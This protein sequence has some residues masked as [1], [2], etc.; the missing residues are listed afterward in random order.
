MKPFKS[1]TILNLLSLFQAIITTELNSAAYSGD[2]DLLL[3]LLKEHNVDECDEQGR[4]P[5][6]H[7]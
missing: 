6:V 5:L 2:K 4:T 3:A 1:S 7:S